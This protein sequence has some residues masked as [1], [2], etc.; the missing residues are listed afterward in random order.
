MET[1]DAVFA[2]ND[3]VILVT[4]RK[5]DTCE[6]KTKYF[7]DTIFKNSIKVV[8]TY[9]GRVRNKDEGEHFG[10]KDGISQPALKDIGLSKPGQRVVKPGVIILGGRR[11]EFTC[12][13]IKL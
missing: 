5:Q 13:Y 3:G 9:E 10:W 11:Q 12:I 8:T 2:S 1:Y 4:A 6:M 7:T